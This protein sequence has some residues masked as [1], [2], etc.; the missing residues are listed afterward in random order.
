MNGAE[1]KEGIKLF[2]EISSLGNGYLQIT[3][4]WVLLKKNDEKYDLVKAETIFYI[5]NAFLRFIGAL[6]EPFMPSFTAKLYEIMNIKYEGESLNLLGIINDFIE[7]NPSESS[8]FLIKTKLIEEGHAINK[9]KPLFKEISQEE[10]NKFKE[11]FK[12]KQ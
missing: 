4:P 3:Q 1:I 2:M 12:G 7:K 8:L 5:L 10:N 6:A 9:P 11:Q